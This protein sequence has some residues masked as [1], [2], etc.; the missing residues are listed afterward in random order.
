VQGCAFWGF[1]DIPPHLDGQTLGKNLIFTQLC[2]CTFYNYQHNYIY[3]QLTDTRF[4]VVACDV[5][6]LQILIYVF[7]SRA[8]LSSLI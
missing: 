1:F 7:I 3:L 6:Q 5:G 8:V 2:M 4:K